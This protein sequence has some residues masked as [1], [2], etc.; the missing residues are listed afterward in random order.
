MDHI[1]GQAVQPVAALAECRGD[2]AAAVDIDVDT[3]NAVALGVHD[4]A[5]NRGI[6]R[7]APVIIAVAIVI[8]GI[9]AAVGPAP[10][11]VAEAAVAPAASAAAGE[12]TA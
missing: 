3:G 12:Q 2:D 8:A 11:R 6:G 1:A 9:C 5:D 4:F 7:H 10:A